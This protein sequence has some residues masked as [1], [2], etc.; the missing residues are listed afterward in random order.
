MVLSVSVQPGT[1]VAE[2]AA[3]V[4]VKEEGEEDG[5]GSLG[6]LVRIRAALR[7]RPSGAE[8][9]DSRLLEKSGLCGCIL[10]PRADRP[11]RS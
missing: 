1:V 11:R 2:A 7:L 4:A 9:A 8:A 6:Y 3:A 10:G 5:V